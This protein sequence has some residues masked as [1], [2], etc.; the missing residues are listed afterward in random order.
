[1]ETSALQPCLV[2]HPLL[3]N[4]PS[5]LRWTA[6]SGTMHFQRALG[7]L[8]CVFMALGAIGVNARMRG[9]EET[10]PRLYKAQHSFRAPFFIGTRTNETCN[11]LRRCP[12]SPF[13]AWRCVECVEMI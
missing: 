1:M 2:V 6:P 10:D 7:F 13:I 8:L 11:V 4:L 3:Q 9:L 12:P 5:S